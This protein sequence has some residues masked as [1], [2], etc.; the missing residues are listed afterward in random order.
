VGA[1]ATAGA[2]ASAWKEGT[3]CTEELVCGLPRYNLGSLLWR[4]TSLCDAWMCIRPFRAK[5]WRLIWVSVRFV[6]MEAEFQLWFHHVWGILC[7]A[8]CSLLMGTNLLVSSMSGRYFSA[9]RWRCFDCH[10]N[11]ARN[12]T[13]INETWV[14]LCRF[15]LLN[16]KTFC[17]GFS[18]Y[19]TR[20]Q[21]LAPSKYTVIS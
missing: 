19:V 12:G 10:T 15:H 11:F 2:G 16:S 1:G 13:F 7:S 21:V 17:L 6:K 14:E 9:L 4:G 3:R 18:V 20:W 8:H 5:R